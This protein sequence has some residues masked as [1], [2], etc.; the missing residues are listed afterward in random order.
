M[1]YSGYL[2]IGAGALSDCVIPNKR[3]NGL[4]HPHPNVELSEFTVVT[5]AP[6]RVWCL[7]RQLHDDVAQC[8]SR[9]FKRIC[10][11]YFFYDIL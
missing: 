3:T 1:V 7:G 4:R 8:L 2:A 6:R 11:V 5:S 9:Q 10:L